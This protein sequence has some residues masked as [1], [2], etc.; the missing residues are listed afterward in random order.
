MASCSAK[1]NNNEDS[2]ALLH[3]NPLKSSYD[4]HTSTKITFPC[5]NEYT[6]RLF[7]VET[8]EMKGI[9]CDICSQHS[10]DD[11][12]SDTSFPY[13]FYDNDYDEDFTIPRLN[14]AQQFQRFK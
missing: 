4:P 9:N 8:I 11:S 13:D 10:T 5:I 12:D 3:H 1:Y 2:L 6:A 14:L 7:E